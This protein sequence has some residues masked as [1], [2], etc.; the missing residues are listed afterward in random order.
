MKRLILASVTL[1]ALTGIDAALAGD[2]PP[3]V[4]YPAGTPPG[5]VYPAAPPGVV[6]PAPA[7]NFTFT[8]YYVGLFQC[9]EV[10]LGVKLLEVK[11]VIFDD[12][13]ASFGPM[14]SRSR[15][16]DGR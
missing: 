2:V 3:A 11:L 1:L 4:I 12:L 15:Q 5:V 10:V 16:F 13:V 6:Y 7:P 14:L 8:G 9:H